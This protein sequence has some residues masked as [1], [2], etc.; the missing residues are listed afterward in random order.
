MSEF[1]EDSRVKYPTIIHLVGMGY[2]YISSNTCAKPRELHEPYDPMTNILTEK[3]REAYLRLNPNSSDEDVESKL[4]AIQS[5]LDFDDLGKDFYNK[6]FLNSGVGRIIDLTSE[7]AF[8]NNNTFQIATEMRCGD[9]RSDNF[10]P[11]ITL[12]VNGLPLAFIEVKKHNNNKGIE[13]ESDRMKVRFQNRKFRRFLNITQIMG[14]SNDMNYADN[15]TNAIQGAFYAAIGRTTTKYNCF[16]ED[17]QTSFPKIINYTRPKDEVIDE[18]LS[19]MNKQV[20]KGASW[21]ANALEASTPTKEL[22]ESLFAFNR[23][24]FLLKYGIA[25]VNEP[26]GLQKHIMRYPQVF[27]TKAIEKHLSEGKECGVIWHTQGSGK[28]ALTYFNVKYLTDFYSKQGIIPQFF[29]IVDRIDL[30]EQAQSEFTKRGLRVI[31]VDSKE[32]FKK[33]VTSDSTTFNAEGEREIIV[34]NIQ[35]FASDARATS[36]NDYNLQVKRIYFIDEAHR[37]YKPNGSFLKN[38]LLTDRNAIRIALTGTPIVSHDYNTKDIFGEYIHTYYYNASIADG[39]T[40]RLIREVIA[41]NF[42]IRMQEIL[43]QI[44]VEEHAVKKED[45]YAHPNFVEPMLDYV[46]N[47]LKKFRAKGNDFRNTGGMMVC[48]SSNQARLMFQLFLQKY[49]DPSEV[50]TIYDEDG[51]PSYSPVSPDTIEAT[52]KPVKLG[53]LRAA[54]ILYD[55]TSKEEKTKWID[56]YKSGKVDLLIV[57][58]AE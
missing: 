18:I 20:F 43:K 31:T 27:A 52:N 35:K 15:N 11:D 9:E 48:S 23:F 2:E 10:R 46:V 6:H 55:S 12:F 47:D 42:K 44:Q 22:A 37:D 33:I 51:V 56:L 16:R 8:V 14:F 49:A 7:E 40:L 28:T 21:F 13:A 41:S 5:S 19:D 36:R 39:Y 1:S 29:F 3:F 45:I 24:F 26:T 58:V 17:G 30:L 53:C 4:A 32:E 50:T 34:V 38:L 25:Y 54:L 57:H